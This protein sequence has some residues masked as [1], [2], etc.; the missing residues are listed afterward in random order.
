VRTALLIGLGGCVGGG[1]LLREIDRERVN[2]TERARHDERIAIARELHDVVAHHVTGIVV[3]AQAAQLV[4]DSRPAA[5]ASALASIEH[6]G[7][8]A[9][10]AMRRMVGA[11]RDDNA[12]APIS[13]A[14]TIRDLH[15]LAAR[16]TALGL[17]VRLVID[18]AGEL[19]RELP[20]EL[21]VSIHR[22]IREA[23]TNARQHAVGATVVDVSV[24]RNGG[25]LDVTIRDDGRPLR[26]ERRNGGFGLVG[27]AE[28]V[29]ALGGVFFAG[30]VAEGGWQVHARLPLG[31]DVDRRA[32][33][34]EATT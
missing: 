34:A 32:D 7:S 12:D 5:T 25:Q 15:D 3:Q 20:I 19:S 27:M 26:G 22:I 31:G 29:H 10:A 17:P 9:L 24:A 28:R 21:A 23:L 30:P 6:A 13:P 1:L 16:S 18:E 11:L 8:E 14:A 4:A 2:E 33:R